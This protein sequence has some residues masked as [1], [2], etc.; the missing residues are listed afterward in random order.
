MTHSFNNVEGQTK[1]VFIEHLKGEDG[2]RRPPRPEAAEEKGEVRVSQR[3]QIPMVFIFSDAVGMED[4]DS[5]LVV[6]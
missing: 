2:G 6:G 5:V 3:S 4:A 1:I